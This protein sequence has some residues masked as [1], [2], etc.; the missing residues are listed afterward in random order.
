M[1][2]TQLTEKTLIPVSFILIIAGAIFWLT[3]IW[4]NTEENTRATRTLKSELHEEIRVLHS[5]DRRLS[6]IE[7]KLNINLNQNTSED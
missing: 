4:A 6:R 2:R 7:G 3:E 1:T 5:I